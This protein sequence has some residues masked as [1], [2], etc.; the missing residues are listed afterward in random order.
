MDRPI[1]ATQ[2]A[3]RKHAPSAPPPLECSNDELRLGRGGEMH[4]GRG[5]ADVGRVDQFGVPASCARSDTHTCSG[6]WNFFWLVDPHACFG[7]WNF[8]WFERKKWHDCQQATGR[9]LGVTQGGI[10]NYRSATMQPCC[11]ECY[12]N[13]LWSA[14]H[15]SRQVGRKP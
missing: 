15:H 8:C 11:S 6:W 1:T 14:V 10:G 9:L 2:V 13:T 3:H 7:W 5:G 12:T 4:L